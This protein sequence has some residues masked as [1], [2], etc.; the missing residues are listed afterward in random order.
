[1]LVPN[2]LDDAWPFRDHASVPLAEPRGVVEQLALRGRLHLRGSYL[3][4]EELLSVQTS[5][6]GCKVYLQ[7]ERIIAI[8]LVEGSRHLGVPFQQVV[9]RAVVAFEVTVETKRN[10][11]Q[12]ALSLP[13][14]LLAHDLD[15]FLVRELARQVRVER[16]DEH[17]PRVAEQHLAFVS[18]EPVVLVLVG[19][20]PKA[21]LEAVRGKP[22]G[23]GELTR[24]MCIL[25]TC[26]QL[27]AMQ[28]RFSVT[29]MISPLCF[30]PYFIEIK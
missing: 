14:V 10:F 20:E 25:G 27:K 18:V 24:W 19:V 4:F 7:L 17:T 3:L 30:V 26:E 11:N 6:L 23:E 16:L 28:I 8:W 15:S 2:V 13:G 21:R 9:L 29:L 5:L 1:M 22:G 12:V